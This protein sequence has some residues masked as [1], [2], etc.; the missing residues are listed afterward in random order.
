VAVPMTRWTS[1]ASSA[2]AASNLT[3]R[4]PVSMVVTRDV[5]AGSLR[6]EMGDGTSSA[7]T[8][9]DVVARLLRA[10][11]QSGNELWLAVEGRS[12]W[13]TIQP[14]ARVRLT[15]GER[16]RRGE[17]WAF[18]DAGEVIVVH[19]CERRAGPG[20]VFRGDGLPGPD[21]WVPAP[22]LIGHVVA[23]EDP[24]GRRCLGRRDRVVGM[25]RTIHHRVLAV[26]RKSRKW[27]SGLMAGRRDRR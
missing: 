3:R 18:V 26:T 6:A 15:A 2:V 23:V 9:P 5:A 19:R 20:Y 27:A 17:V 7:S 11:L 24:K 22:R 16:P 8:G 25:G 14:P 13:P 21:P 10:R 12:M 1:S 4:P